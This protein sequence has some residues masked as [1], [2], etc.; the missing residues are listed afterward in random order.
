MNPDNHRKTFGIAFALRDFGPAVLSRTDA[1]MPWTAIRTEQYRRIR[2]GI[3]A[4]WKCLF[5]QLFIEEKASQGVACGVL[6]RIHLELGNLVM[7]GGAIHLTLQIFASKALLP[8]TCLNVF[9]GVRDPRDFQTAPSIFCPRRR[10]G[11]RAENEQGVVWRSRGQGSEPLEGFVGL[12][13]EDPALFD[14]ATNQ[15][16]WDKA[17]ALSAA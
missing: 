3:S 17:D 10:P 14:Y 2:G 11:P 6:G 12:D 15:D 13:C 7:D 1:W 9:Q 5:R 8:C 16:L 4:V